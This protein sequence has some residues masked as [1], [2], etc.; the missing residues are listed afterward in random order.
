MCPRWWW[1]QG[2]SAGCWAV[3]GGHCPP[4]PQDSSSRACRWG[5]GGIVTSVLPWC[6][7]GSRQCWAGCEQCWAGW[8]LQLAARGQCFVHG[9]RVLG[10]TAA[11]AALAGCPRGALAVASAQSCCWR[12]PG[13]AKPVLLVAQSGSGGWG[14]P[15]PGHR[16][17]LRSLLSPLG[18]VQPQS[19]LGRGKQPVVISSLAPAGSGGPLRASLWL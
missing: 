13:G 17:V 11:T 16:A 4:L 12:C 3:S 8:W 14:W 6:G 19:E 1:A 2:S 18:W 5:P 9:H 7:V 15:P 10:A